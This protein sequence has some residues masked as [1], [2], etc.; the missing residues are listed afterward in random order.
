MAKCARHERQP[1]LFPYVP[2]DARRLARV[3][4]LP[5][6][7]GRT[8]TAIGATIYD[9][10]RQGARLVENGA[11]RAGGL[12]A[13]SLQLVSGGLR[14]RGYS[15]VNGIALTGRLPGPITVSG[16]AAAPATLTLRGTRLVGRLGSHHVRLRV[17]LPV[18]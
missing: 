14:L 11:R 16:P 9:A 15:L 13:G 7:E 3:P 1:D 10:I 17:N 6:L 8:A 5:A 12:R 2:G 4:G 18:G